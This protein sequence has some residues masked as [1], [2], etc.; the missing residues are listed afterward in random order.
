MVLVAD[1][2]LR[3]LSGMLTSYSAERGVRGQGGQCFGRNGKDVVL[4]V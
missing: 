3:S 1:S 4:K 2:M